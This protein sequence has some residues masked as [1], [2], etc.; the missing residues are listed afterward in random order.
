MFSNRP[1]AGKRPKGRNTGRSKPRPAPARPIKSRVVKARYKQ[2]NSVMNSFY[3]NTT[4]G[5]PGSSNRKLEVYTKPETIKSNLTNLTNQQ[6]K[7]GTSS[8][9]Q[10]RMEAQVGQMDRL[11]RLKAKAIGD[12]K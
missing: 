3:K 9:G 8:T 4:F 7:N 6:Q 1:N 2:P 12:S 11:A 5:T 10:S